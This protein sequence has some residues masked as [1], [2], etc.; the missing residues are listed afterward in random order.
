MLGSETSWHKTPTLDPRGDT[1]LERPSY[2]V[3]LEDGHQCCLQV[4]TLLLLGVKDVNGML[5][6]LQVDDRSS[7]EVLGEQ[8][9]VHGG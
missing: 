6:A 3:D 9:N 1:N 2:L 8:V 5:P 7:T 4:V